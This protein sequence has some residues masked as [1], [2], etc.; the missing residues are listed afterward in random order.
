M[1]I[2]ILWNTQERAAQQAAGVRL[3]PGILYFGCRRR[4]Q[5]YIYAEELAAAEAS[6]TLSRLSVAFSRDG[7]SKVYVQHHLEQDAGAWP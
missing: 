7:A 4:E 5:D 6:G 1:L 2:P 3:G